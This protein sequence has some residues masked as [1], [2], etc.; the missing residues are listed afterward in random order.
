MERNC[1]FVHNHKF[2][3]RCPS[4]YAFNTK[5][6]LYPSVNQFDHELF[7]HCLHKHSTARVLRRKSGFCTETCELYLRAV[8]IGNLISCL[9]PPRCWIRGSLAPPSQH[10]ARLSPTYIH[11]GDNDGLANLA[12]GSVGESS[13]DS[14]PRW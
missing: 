8:A 12:S 9:G 7:L 1:E 5:S 3:P 14:L 6:S 2:I 11:I 10:P 13:A 4:C